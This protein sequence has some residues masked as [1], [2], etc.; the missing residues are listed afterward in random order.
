MSSIRNGAASGPDVGARDQDASE[1]HALIGVSPALRQLVAMI[2]RVA[3]TGHTLLIVG[4]TGSGKELVARRLHANGP[5]RDMPFIDVNCGAIPHDL[6]EAEFFGHVRG[7]FTGAVEH[8]R[9]LFEQVGSGTLFLDEIGELPLALQPKLL[10]VLETRTFR[11]IGAS[12]SLRF[13]GRVV[14]ATHRNLLEDARAGRFRE[15][16]FYRLAVF[17][18]NVPGL[19]QRSEDIP[20]LAAHFAARQARALA[21]TPAAI[22]RL[23]EQPWPGNVR[24]LR[25][26]VSQLSV[27]AQH[28]RIDAETLAPFLATDAHDDDARAHLADRLLELGGDDKLAAAEQLLIDRA[29]ERTSNN[30]SAA[31]AMLGVSRKVIERRL[32]AREVQHGEARQCL[33]C[34]EA[35][36]GSGQLREAV[37]LLRRCVDLLHKASQTEDG[38]RLLFGAYRLLAVSLR[39]VNGWQCSEA[40]ECYKAALSI[41]DGVCDAFELAAVQFGVWTTQLVTLQLSKARA[42]AQ[43]LIQ[44]AHAM[45]ERAALDEAH[46]ALA[47]TLFWLGDSEEAL[48]SLSRG[49]L[50]GIG[51]ADRRLGVQGVD[52][53]GLAL[54]LEGLAAY[55]TG[56]VDDA[57]RAMDGLIAR[58]DEEHPHS[59]S[60]AVDLQGAAWLAMLFC[61]TDRLGDLTTALDAVSLA[62]RPA[63]CSGAARIF[64]ACYLS[65]VGKDGEAEAMLL[66]GYD[67]DIAKHGGALFHSIKA[68]KHGELLLSTGRARQCEALVSEAIDEVIR[69]QERAYLG[70]LLIV[71]ARAQWMLGDTGAAE[72]GLRIAI[73]TALA[74]GSVPARLAATTYLAELLRQPART[75]PDVEAHERPLHVPAVALAGP[76]HARGML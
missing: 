20:L 23:C 32:K 62:G 31:A 41:G 1:A 53:A 35:L 34:A 38:C 18:L 4:P 71:K 46:V 50:R 8:H 27:F 75:T 57:R 49:G 58:S 16:L 40:M 17:I 9:G 21:F 70:E 74:L 19:A 24:Q 64:R 22:K 6:I 25:N 72:Q 15:D 33:E 43:E 2:D 14:A 76:N 13:D 29:L 30:K 47:N 54:T 28:P 60:R 7:A 55:Q 66:D 37:A 39:G 56:S 48:A 73:S 45:G 69:R 61:D 3:P 36:I 11:P 65:M 68:W 5:R 26:L 59:P 44:R 51:R 67:N 63:C 42:T 52:V 12:A 10:R